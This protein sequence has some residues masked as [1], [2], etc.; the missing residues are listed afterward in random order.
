MKVLIHCQTL[1][2][3]PILYLTFPSAKLEKVYLFGDRVL[4]NVCTS[5]PADCQMLIGILLLGHNSL[6]C[7]PYELCSPAAL[8]YRLKFKIPKLLFGKIYRLKL[9]K[10]VINAIYNT[11]HNIHSRLRTRVVPRCASLWFE[12]DRPLRYRRVWLMIAPVPE[13]SPGEDGGL[14]LVSIIIT[15]TKQITTNIECVSFIPIKF[16]HWD[17]VAAPDRLLTPRLMQNVWT[18]ISG[19]EKCPTRI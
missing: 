13:K 10:V 18:C 9:Q 16:P 2:A 14:I 4:V 3:Q 8:Y 7:I 1:T 17:P 11:V 6:I 5:S 15:T 12:I 19:V